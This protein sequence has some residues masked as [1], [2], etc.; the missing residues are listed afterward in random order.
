MSDTD[1]DRPAR[2][3]AGR[4]AGDPV[5]RGLPGAE[6]AGARRVSLPAGAFAHQPLREATRFRAIQVVHGRRHGPCDLHVLRRVQRRYWK[7]VGRLARRVERPASAD[8]DECLQDTARLLLVYW[9]LRVEHLPVEETGAWNRFQFHLRIKLDSRLVLP[10][11]RRSRGGLLCVRRMRCDAYSI[12]QD[13]IP[14]PSVSM[15]AERCGDMLKAVG[16]DEPV[17]KLAARAND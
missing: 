1:P 15:L 8:P 9:L 17:V 13:P 4:G 2:D 3:D 7:R 11:R 6:N 10:V 5:Q 14:R 16:G 12:M